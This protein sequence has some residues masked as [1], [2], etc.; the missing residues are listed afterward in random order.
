MNLLIVDDDPQLAY[1][2]G[3]IFIRDGWT[4]TTAHSLK[5]ART[6]PG[7]YDVVVADVRLQ[8]GD[9]RELRADYPTTPFVV[10]SGAHGEVPD[11]YKPFTAEQLRTA[12]AVAMGV[13]C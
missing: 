9:G 4:V 10:I 6:K 12:I 7:S 1:L 5:E 8:N 13:S 2:M 11:L 3:K